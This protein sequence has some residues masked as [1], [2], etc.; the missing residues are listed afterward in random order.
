MDELERESRFPYGSDQDCLEQLESAQREIRAL[1]RQLDK[2][3]SRQHE[4]NRALKLT[5]TNLAEAKRQHKEL[6]QDR[7]HW[8]SRAEHHH[9]SVS[10]GTLNPS[11][12]EIAA[13]RK[14]LVRLH[15]PDSGGDEDRMKLWFTALEPNQ[16]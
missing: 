4:V 2:E 8:Q 1:E 16:E 7:K 6:L 14:A 11:A 13:I 5:V 3:R 10:F 15:H 12:E 9:T